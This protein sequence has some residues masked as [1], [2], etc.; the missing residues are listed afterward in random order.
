MKKSLIEKLGKFNPMRPYVWELKITESEFRSLEEDLCGYTPNASHKEDALKMIV[1]IAE[2]YKRRYTCKAKKAYQQT[3]G[4]TKPDLETAWQ[5]LGIDEQYLYRGENG[6]KL[7]LYST[8]ILSGLAVK[9]ERQKNERSFLRALCR[10][11]NDED[12]SFDRVV[13]SNH[14]TAFKE[15]IAKGH[16]L[17][18]FLEAII[19]SKEMADEALPYAKEDID[20]SETEV[21]L[22]IE[23]IREI[24][25]EVNKSK[26]RYEWI[27]TAIPGD[28]LMS[29]KLHL[30]LNPEEKGKLHQLLRMERLK[31]WGFAEPENMRY[32]QLGVRY[33]NGNAVVK[34]PDFHHPDLYYRN[35]GDAS[36]GFI[37]EKENY[38]V[39]RN[40]PVVAFDRIQLIAWQEDGTELSNPVQEDT[41]DFDAMQLYRLAEGEDDWT[42]RVSNQKE[43]ALLFADNW[44]IADTS[45]DKLYERKTFYN[46]KVGEGNGMSWCYIQTS[47]TIKDDAETRTYYNRQG[48]D[49]IVARRYDD[50]ISYVADGKVM[51]HHAD[52]EE[53][54]ETVTPIS[55]IFGKKDIIAY[56]TESKDGEEDQCQV[57]EIELCEYK[58][59]GNYTPWTEADAPAYGYVELRI[60]VKGRPTLFKA[61]YLPQPITRDLEAKA[62]RYCNQKKEEQVYD[63]KANIEAA[64][65]K[66]QVLEPTVIVNV[67]TE[68]DR[69]AIPVYRP[70]CLKEII[71]ND[72]LLKYAEEATYELPYILRTHMK[73]RSYGEHG[74]QAYDCAL[75]SGLHKLIKEKR[76]NNP[77]AAW[78]SSAA[79]EKG[80][81]YQASAIDHN[82]PDF[83]LLK[84]G[85]KRQRELNGEDFYFWNYDQSQPLVKMPRKGV[86]SPQDWGMIFQSN[87]RN[88]T[89][90][91]FY[92][93]YNEEDDD[94]FEDDGGEHFD[95]VSLVQCFKMAVEHEL[96]FFT[97]TP[98]KNLTEEDFNEQLLVP[99]LEEYKGALPREI[100]MGVRRFIEEYDFTDKEK[101]YNIINQDK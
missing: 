44:E 61:F 38:A 74:F 101:Y 37:C 50:T 85:E 60:T 13:D 2:W 77:N 21:T 29:R 70:V 53:S 30:W 79:W 41:V 3:F 17:R 16:C 62:I 76:P 40:V 52:D 4:G 27:V 15:S 1:Y 7:T 46:K 33:W 63:D 94:I 45:V 11:Y 90:K 19:T 73:V 31:K 32:I 49:H 78:A 47:V 12:E 51:W 86:T 10:V 80:D 54:P 20:D 72:N 89:G 6:Q 69:I 35:T 93:L 91:N 84:M 65:R 24:N 28:S 58:R 96:H 98:L 42:S 25:Y 81:T 43:T 57:G 5:T 36:I 87:K 71:Y 67:G 59:N 22:L 100:G 66:R 88:R 26:F 92:P 75:L 39:C 48:Y 56:H 9:F 99:L 82:A 83:L 18:H 95:N 68:T 23:L 34:E 8:F 14:S 97:L 64:M 55:L